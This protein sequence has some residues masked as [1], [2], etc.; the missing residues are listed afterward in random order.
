MSVRESYPLSLELYESTMGQ[1]D[2]RLALAGV[3]LS[4]AQ[5]MV[6]VGEGSLLIDEINEARELISSVIQG[7]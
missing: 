5:E 1:H 4:N 7:S 6:G 3:I 2:G